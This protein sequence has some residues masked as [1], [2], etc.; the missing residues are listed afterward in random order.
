LFA[1]LE[2]FAGLRDQHSVRHAIRRAEFV[3]LR[4]EST[5]RGGVRPGLGRGNSGFA[6]ILRSRRHTYRRIEG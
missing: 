1:T 2:P 3:D 6:F 5:V 4:N